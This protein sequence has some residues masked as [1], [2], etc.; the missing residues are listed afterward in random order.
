MATRYRVQAQREAKERGRMVGMG[1]DGTL[2]REGKVK[3][4]IIR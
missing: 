4:E 2:Y 1:E 3:K